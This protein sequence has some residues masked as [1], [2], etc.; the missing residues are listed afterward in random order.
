MVR[1]CTVALA[2]RP[3]SLAPCTRPASW[4]SVR[5]TSQSLRRYWLRSYLRLMGRCTLRWW[6]VALLRSSTPFA[7]S[8]PSS[9]SPKQLPTARNSLLVP[10]IPTRRSSLIS[11]QQ[12]C[13]LSSLFRPSSA[14]SSTA[15]Q[16][17]QRRSRPAPPS[18]ATFHLSVT[19]QGER[20]TRRCRRTLRVQSIGARVL[21]PCSLPWCSFGARDRQVNRP[22]FQLADGIVDKDATR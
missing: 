4:R 18:S 22:L 11:P 15:T 10:T 12:V 6:S 9:S 14:T 1:W 19:D 8:S 21:W 5:C 2:V 17:S 20:T 16:S 13:T 7:S 3:A